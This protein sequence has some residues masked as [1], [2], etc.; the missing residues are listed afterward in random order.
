MTALMA[1][2]E[3]RSSA[4]SQWIT[5]LSMWDCPRRSISA[6]S[7][8]HLKDYHVRLVPMK[9]LLLCNSFLTCDKNKFDIRAGPVRDFGQQVP[10]STTPRRPRANQGKD[11]IRL[12]RLSCD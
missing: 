7:T 11:R 12:Q 1:S 4:G 6:S 10:S 3:T 5:A 2:L 9:R 8:Q